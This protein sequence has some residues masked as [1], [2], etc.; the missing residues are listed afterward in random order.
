MKRLIMIII[1]SALFATSKSGFSAG[2]PSIGKEKSI[3]CSACHGPDGNSDNSDYPSLAG[4]VPGYI[5]QQLAKFKSGLRA[6]AI[7]GG[8][9]QT[10]T[11]EDMEDLDAWYSSQEPDVFMITE[12]Q[13]G[14][15]KLGEK[16][17]RAGYEPMGIPA[18]MGCHGPAGAGIPTNFPRIAGQHSEYT[19]L[20]LMAFKSGQR[21]SEIMNPIA[22]RLSSEQMRALA[23]YISALH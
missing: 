4:Q 11:D 14:I 16:L 7:M 2:D 17:Y 6:N 15:A 19:E 23:L 12:D 21:Q 13:L 10:L 9:T 3:V 22:F 1:A 5:A 18:C 8:L 20:Q